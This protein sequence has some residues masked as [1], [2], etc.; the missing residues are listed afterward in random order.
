M[1][2]LKKLRFATVL[3]LCSFVA[4]D[5]ATETKSNNEA[6][7]VQDRAATTFTF[8]EDSLTYSGAGK[9]FKTT[10]AYNDAAASPLPVVLVVPEWWGV[11][12]YTKS[13]VK[14]LA[15]LGYLAMAVDMYTEGKTADNPEGAQKLAMPFYKD[16]SMAKANFDAALAKVKTLPQADTSKIAAIGYCF[17]GSMVLNMARMGENLKGVV[18]FHGD[19]NG[20]GLSAKKDEVKPKVL[21]LHGEADSMV[22]ADVVAAFK[23]EMDGAAVDYKFIGYP[24]AKHAFTNPGATAVGEKYKIDIAYNEAADKS[25]WEEMKTFLAGIFK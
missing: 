10:V 2:H 13:R 9:N 21:V 15:E 17:G 24:G 6:D 1:K 16:P 7:S 25:S 22:P 11:N 5:N 20:Y 12:D 4:C 14:Q 19:L 3:S 23:K 18:S 8:K